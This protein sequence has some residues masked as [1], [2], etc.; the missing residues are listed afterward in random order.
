[1][2]VS[3][4]ELFSSPNDGRA[5]G[6]AGF[7]K[8]GRGG[9]R[10]NPENRASDGQRKAIDRPSSLEAIIQLEF[11]QPLPTPSAWRLSR[12]RGRRIG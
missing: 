5:R 12:A 9:H 2:S 10:G 8:R 3:G 11:G 7:F 4:V 6:E 1:M